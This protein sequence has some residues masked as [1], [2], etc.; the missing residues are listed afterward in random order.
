MKQTI[1]LSIEVEN[2]MFEYFGVRSFEHKK[3][4]LWIYFEDKK[5]PAGLIVNDDIRI[6]HAYVTDLNITFNSIDDME[7]IGVDVK[8]FGGKMTFLPK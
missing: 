8:K 5:F 7:F 4:E 2:V 1:R 3:G 6:C